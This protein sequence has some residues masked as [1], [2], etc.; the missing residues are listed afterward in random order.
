MPIKRR[1][2]KTRRVHK[3]KEGVRSYKEVIKDGIFSFTI[4]FQLTRNF[5]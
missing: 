2:G 4:W 1:Q 3:Q 5:Y